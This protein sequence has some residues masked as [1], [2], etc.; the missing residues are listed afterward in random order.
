MSTRRAVASHQLLL[1]SVKLL[2]ILFSYFHK[3]LINFLRQCVRAAVL[4]A[5]QT[6]AKKEGNALSLSFSKISSRP[7]KTSKKLIFWNKMYSVFVIILDYQYT[8]THIEK[9]HR[10]SY[11]CGTSKR[12]IR[13]SPL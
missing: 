2:A 6:A 10:R 4:S 1:F 3:S 9:G 7:T 8:T 12:G 13:S 11:N 5:A